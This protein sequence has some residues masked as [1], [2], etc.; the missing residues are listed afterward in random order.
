MC[1]FE[2]VLSLA[3]GFAVPE[4]EMR[5]ALADSLGSGRDAARAQRIAVREASPGKLQAHPEPAPM[6]NAS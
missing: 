1:D 4:Q 6:R 3:R 5:Q 2:F